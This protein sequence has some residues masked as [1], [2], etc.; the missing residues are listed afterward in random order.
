MDVL[1]SFG[2]LDEEISEKRKYAKWKAAYIHN[3]LKQGE[4]PTPGSYGQQKEY[5][6]TK[7]DDTDDQT[8]DDSL[9]PG[10]HSVPTHMNTTPM[11][12]T[13]PTIPSNISPVFPNVPHLPSVTNLPSVPNIP[14][15]PNL[16]S[17]PQMPTQPVFPTEPTYVT[18]IQPSPIDMVVS[19]NGVTLNAEQI[20]KAQKYCKFAS[21]ALNYDDAKTAID[22]LQKALILL[23]TGRDSPE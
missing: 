15:E 14:S 2:D 7:I 23:Q 4:R 21:S 5:G 22:N 16:S 9:I 12:P 13:G 18:P 1:S 19:D 11:P 20:A 3:C 6:F 17:V 8:N 10:F